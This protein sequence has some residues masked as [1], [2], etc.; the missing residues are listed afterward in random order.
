MPLPA[1]RLASDLHCMTFV[2][3]GL[4]RIRDGI[5]RSLAKSASFPAPDFAQLLMQLMS[6][7]VPASWAAPAFGLGDDAG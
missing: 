4:F 6:L 5:K 2:A 7:S 1:N 3:S